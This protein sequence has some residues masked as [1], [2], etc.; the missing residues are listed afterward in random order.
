MRLGDLL[1]AAGRSE[2]DYAPSRAGAV[3]FRLHADFKGTL[4]K[5]ET[6]VS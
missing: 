1:N 4:Q 3:P 2:F 5:G 6:F